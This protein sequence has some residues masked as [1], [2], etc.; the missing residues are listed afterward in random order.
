MVY[1]PFTVIP[2]ELIFISAVF[3]CNLF[4][5]LFVFFFSYL[6]AFG[7]FFFSLSSLY[8]VHSTFILL[9]VTFKI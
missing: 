1:C 6:M 7:L 9:V 8:I 5:I 3:L 2:D 4:V